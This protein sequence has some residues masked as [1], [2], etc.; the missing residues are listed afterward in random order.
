MVLLGAGSVTACSVYSDA[1]PAIGWGS[2][3]TVQLT[4]DVDEVADIRLCVDAECSPGTGDD[5][6]AAGHEISP[7]QERGPKAWTFALAVAPEEVSVRTYTA[8]GSVLTETLVTPEWHRVGGT[9][10]CGGPHAA[11]VTVDV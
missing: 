4:G 1:C 10:R 2:S 7:A 9:A 6:V 5:T 8:D 11:A 3:F